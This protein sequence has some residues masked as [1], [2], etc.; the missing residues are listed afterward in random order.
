MTLER[1]KFLREQFRKLRVSLDNDRLEAKSKGEAKAL[2]TAW[3]EVNLAWC[4]LAAIFP[5]EFLND[6]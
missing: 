3:D 4:R 6:D 5:E 1:F 2:E